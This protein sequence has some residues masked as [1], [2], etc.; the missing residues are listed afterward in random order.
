M[1]LQMKIRI[2][3][4]TI[5][6]FIA[7]H[8]TVAS[9][10]VE[11]Q[12]AFIGD[13]KSSAYKGVEQGIIEANLQGRFLGQT[14]SLRRFDDS[15]LSHIKADEYIAI[16]AALN[17]DTLRRLS[18][19]FPNHPVLN[20]SIHDDALRQT[21][22]AN[23]LHV[24][25]GNKMLNDA[26][27]QWL[28]KNPGEPVHSSGWHDDFKKFAAR[29]L[30]KRYRKRFSVSMDQYAWAGWAAVKMTSDS[31]AREGITS[32]NALLKYL[33]SEEMAFDGQKG[34]NMTFRDTGQLRQLILL[35]DAEGEL[36]G[37]APVRGIAKPGDVDSLGIVSCLN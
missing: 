3:T 32:A 33:R 13:A 34:L 1:A 20:I 35:S 26:K 9:Q 8:S 23:M 36:I 4:A 14:Y 28:Q 18:S 29:D 12:Y 16:I 27:Q 24:I 11:I 10:Q 17:A 6:L 7:H 2:I 15:D 22:T 5:L 19:A 31:V 25:P 30:N 37:E 21:C